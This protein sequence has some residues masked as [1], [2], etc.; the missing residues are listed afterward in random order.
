MAASADIIVIGAGV[1][2][3]SASLQ[4]AGRGKRVVLL[5]KGELASG[6]TALA[7]GLLGQ[8]RSTPEATWMLMESIDTLKSIERQVGRQV[9]RQSGSVRVAQDDYRVHE[10]REHVAIAKEAGLEVEMVSP[11]EAQ[12]RVPYMRADDVIEAAFCPTDGY[13]SPP[14][15]AKLYIEAARMNGVA[16]MPHRRV[17][18]I[19]I[20]G[21][22]TRGV[23]AGGE[24]F[25]APLVINA[26]GPWSYLISDL[27]GEKLPT[28]A[29]GHYYFTTEPDPRWRIDPAS[30]TLRDREN[31]IYSRPTAEGGLRVGIYEV[32]PVGYDMEDFSADFE[33]TGMKAEEGHPSVR[34][35]LEAAG[36]RFPFLK[37]RPPMK[38]TTGIMS[39]TPD[40]DP[41][42]GAFPEVEGLFHCAGFCGH[43]VMQSAVIGVLVAELVLDGRCRYDLRKIEADRFHDVP[44]L[45]DRPEVKRRCS[46]VYSGYYARPA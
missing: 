43:G 25:H 42:V 8:M 16:L 23:R 45:R 1:A 33:M 37:E 20:E 13:L 15:L 19:L 18:S 40:G 44:W 10:L 14:E 27:A 9:F 24:E 11:G 22:K 32:G 26:A 46:S 4:L 17:E 6:S 30:A 31:L 12:R 28:A 5:D 34:L 41:L 3:L 7:A 38:F 29:I 36:R 2:G 35:L 21:G 39:F